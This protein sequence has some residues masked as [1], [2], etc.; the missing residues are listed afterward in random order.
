MRLFFYLLISVI[1]KLWSALQD[2]DEWIRISQFISHR[3][4]FSRA[5]G[6]NTSCDAVKTG[7][8]QMMS[9]S[10][11]IFQN[12][13][14]SLSVFIP[15]KLL[16]WIAPREDHNLIFSWQHLI[17]WTI[18]L[19]AYKRKQIFPK[20]SDLMQKYLKDNK[21]NDPH[22]VRRLNCFVLLLTAQ[23]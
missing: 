13:P 3:I 20:E 6:L 19:N 15:T 7:R 10:Q 14:L 16:N 22:F 23:P 12:F 9:P 18:C 5:I 17:F 1:Q 11:E 8:Y 2:V 21:R 4:F